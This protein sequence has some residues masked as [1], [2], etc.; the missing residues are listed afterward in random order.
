MLELSLAT[1]MSAFAGYLGS[2]LVL[3]AVGTAIFFIGHATAGRMRAFF[4]VGHER[5][6]GRERRF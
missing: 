2:V 4:L 3:F 1:R 5:L 6:L